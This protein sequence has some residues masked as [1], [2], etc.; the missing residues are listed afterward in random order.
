MWRK[1]FIA[2]ASTGET[3]AASR[4][5]LFENH[6]DESGNL[7]TSQ[8][9]EWCGAGIHPEIDHPALQN[10][11][12]AEF[13]P[14]WVELLSTGRIV[15]AIVAD[16]PDS[17]REILESQGIFA[18][19]I[20]P[21][22]V[23]GKFWGFIGFDNCV[24]DRL[25]EPAQVNL[26]RAVAAAISAHLERQQARLELVQAKEVAEA[27]NPA[28][29]Q[30]LARMSHELRT[31]LNA[32]IGFSQL[33]EKDAT[34]HAEQQEYIQTINRSGE[35][36]LSLI[37][38]VL[39]MSKIEA[40]KVY[41]QEKSVHLPQLL[42]DLLDMLRLKAESQGLSLQL[43][44]SEDLPDLVISDDAKLRQILINLLGNAI[45]FTHQGSITLR[46]W[47]IEFLQQQYHLGFE[48]EDTG[49]G[50]APAELD[51]IFEVFGQSEA[52]K[53]SQ[54]G[55]G[56]GLPIS[57]KFVELMGGTLTVRSMLG[58]GS[59]F[60]FDIYTKKIQLPVKEVNSDCAERSAGGN[61][62][63]AISAPTTHSNINVLVVDDN[64]VNCKFAL[65]MLKRL[66]YPAVAVNSG[67]ETI[68]ILQHQTF[69]V[70]LM[71]VQMPGMDGLETTQK[72]RTLYKNSKQ[73]I[74]GL[75]ADVSSETREQCLANG[76]DDFLCKPVK[77]EIL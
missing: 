55:T 16:F 19:L 31:P 3:S 6:Q 38:D 26:L 69:D 11:T 71:D 45:K 53:Q 65:L 4:V 46:V 64:A 40:G 22:L 13:S 39:E 43:Q 2:F 50:I 9:S 8:K 33:L 59:T 21:L 5:Y 29:S 18:I 77:L 61:R 72:I 52:G 70:V 76:M 35:H 58:V 23:N 75:T 66:G 36:L 63:E 48:I 44:M 74:I 25:W 10:V 30:F 28:K 1:T 32:I 68:E 14:R 7:L 27:A 60:Q 12:Y 54:Q 56:L 57:R 34:L 62:S 49:Q 47:V 51:T 42:M 20:L 24:S 67:E 15:N 17:E 37:D 73:P 41:L